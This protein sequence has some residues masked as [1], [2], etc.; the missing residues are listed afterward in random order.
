[1]MK[2]SISQI[3][4]GDYLQIATKIAKRTGALSIYHLV[5]DL[6]MLR[7]SENPSDN[8]VMI[9]DAQYIDRIVH[10]GD[11]VY[12]YT[13]YI[14]DRFPN[15]PETP[16]SYNLYR[17]EGFVLTLPNSFIC[18]VYKQTKFVKDDPSIVEV[19]QI[20]II[21]EL[22]IGVRE[23]TDVDLQYIAN[24]YASIY[25]NYIAITGMEEDS[26]GSLASRNI[27]I[28]VLTIRESTE[29]N[30]KRF[31]YTI[32]PKVDGLSARLYVINRDGDLY[33]YL[34]FR[35]ARRSVLVSKLLGM[36]TSFD[37]VF[38][39]EVFKNNL[40][41]ELEYFI[42]DILYSSIIGAY[43]LVQRRT[44][45]MNM[46]LELRGINGTKDVIGSFTRYIIVPNSG[47]DITNHVLPITFWTHRMKV[48]ERDPYDNFITFWSDVSNPDN[49]IPL[50]RGLSVVLYPVNSTVENLGAIG[51][52][53][54]KIK[55]PLDNT[56]DS[57][58]SDQLSTASIYNKGADNS[59]IPFVGSKH[60]PCKPRVEGLTSNYANMVSEVS[61][62]KPEDWDRR[63]AIKHMS[64][65]ESLA[66]YAN[67]DSASNI[68]TRNSLRK[69]QT[70][71]VD[72][73]VHGVRTKVY[74]NNM[75]TAISNYQL[76]MDEITTGRILG[77][78]AHRVQLLIEEYAVTE[79]SGILKTYSNLNHIIVLFPL[80][81]IDHLIS[82]MELQLNVP[83]TV[84]FKR[85]DDSDDSGDLDDF[86]KILKKFAPINEALWR[87][88]YDDPIAVIADIRERRERD[89]PNPTVDTLFILPYATMQMSTTQ[90]TEITNQ[91]KGF[92]NGQHLAAMVWMLDFYAL[93][94]K[95]VVYNKLGITV[96]HLSGKTGDKRTIKTSITTMYGRYNRVGIYT[97]G[98]NDQ[99]PYLLL[100]VIGDDSVRERLT[101]A[102][103]EYLALQT[104][105]FYVDTK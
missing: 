50:D 73:E 25:G 100:N 53:V 85:S 58:L 101:T 70:I 9:K 74:V 76:Y 72:V 79:L 10:S 86:S 8:F 27:P 11:G 30:F 3:V 43:N 96:K 77:N 66:F 14:I 44:N 1:M 67:L 90:W 71:K 97:G 56:H 63:D 69:K 40:T 49:V 39:V 103:Q 7:D 41:K 91:I 94:N 105:M 87:L 59:L 17:Q 95:K 46:L 62:L 15:N 98:F 18:K 35:D 60:Y 92:K 31:P 75:S 68:S 33:I 54:Y 26:I 55:S 84:I 51:R 82:V 81:R 29:L 19:G 5:T 65:A 38:L 28:E 12:G 93:P 80:G 34:K 22:D 104:S 23:I 45:M 6:Q 16:I 36:R 4:Y 48:I 21:F 102:E 61:I 99:K 57:V 13:Y 83:I 64:L 24:V 32:N 2:A 37:A 78:T 88:T 20:Y 42:V 89:T 52:K 47:V